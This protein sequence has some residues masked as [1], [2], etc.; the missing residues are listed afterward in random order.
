MKTETT[1]DGDTPSNETN[2]PF[3]KFKDAVRQ[4]MS[5]PKEEI[6]KREAEY[7]KNKPRRKRPAQK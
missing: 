4:I 6:D 7:Q 3:D 1:T 5:V 2:T